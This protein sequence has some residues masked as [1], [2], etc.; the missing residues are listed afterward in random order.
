MHRDR[1]D[2]GT[3][4][5]HAEGRDEYGADYIAEKTGDERVVFRVQE[6][7]NASILPS[8]RYW[9]RVS[10]LCGMI[11]LSHACPMLGQ[12]AG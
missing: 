11:C 5:Q 12:V 10:Q 7:I 2:Y 8:V 4:A 1:M 9:R 3:W 6:A